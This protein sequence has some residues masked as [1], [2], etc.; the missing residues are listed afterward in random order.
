MNTETSKPERVRYLIFSWFYI[1]SSTRYI[2][3]NLLLSGYHIIQTFNIS[4]AL[5]YLSLLLLW[6]IRFFEEMHKL[7]VFIE[8]S[9]SEDEIEFGE[10]VS[11]NSLTL[12]L[13][14]V[15]YR[16]MKSNGERKR[17]RKI[18]FLYT[19]S[20]FIRTLFIFKW[21]DRPR[22]ESELGNQKWTGYQKKKPNICLSKW[23]LYIKIQNEQ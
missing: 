4:L 1:L 14:H 19:A 8:G 11:Q 10:S 7:A 5:K 9:F 13:V 23:I 6:S 21:S 22:K 17:V 12:I 2:F 18:T 15:S 3:W 16:T 20:A